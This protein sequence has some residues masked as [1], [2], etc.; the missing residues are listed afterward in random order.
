[1]DDK[2]KKIRQLIEQSLNDDT[3]RDFYLGQAV[4]IV[5]DILAKSTT[6]KTKPMIEIPDV[7]L[8]NTYVDKNQIMSDAVDRHKNL[9]KKLNEDSIS[10]QNTQFKKLT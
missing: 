2:L 1:M 5:D 7:V 4:A 6:T 9:H 3:K 8:K 10:K